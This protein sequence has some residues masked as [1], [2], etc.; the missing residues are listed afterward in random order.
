MSASQAKIMD[1]EIKLNPQ[2]TAAAQYAGRAQ[3]LLVVAGAGCGKTRTIIARAAHLLS[4]GIDAQRIL[5]LTFTNRAARE[6]KKRLKSEAGPLA[7]NVQ[8]GTFHSFCLKV[9]RRIPRSFEIQGL[10]IIDVDDQ[11]ALMGLARSRVL[12]R[13]EKKLKKLCRNL[14]SSSGTTRIAA[15]RAGSRPNT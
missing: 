12:G 6:M 7:G 5:M 9:M 1:P 2:Q 4:A 3:S 11:N 10:D 8:T 14:L 13:Q 15:T